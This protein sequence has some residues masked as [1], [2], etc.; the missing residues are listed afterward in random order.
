M[1][2]KILSI[3]AIALAL[4]VL[5]ITPA[6]ALSDTPYQGYIYDSYDKSNPAPVGYEPEKVVNQNVLGLSSIGRLYDMDFDKEGNLYVLDSDNS[7]IYIL[8]VNLQLKSTLTLNQDGEPVNFSKAQ[9]IYIHKTGDEKLI[10]IAD[11]EQGR[12]LVSDKDGNVVNVFT[13]PET[14]LIPEST[15][16]RP[17]KVVVSDEETVY[18]LCQHVYSGVLML[19]Q[20]GEFLGFCG[21]NKIEMT[22]AVLF[23]YMWK[24]L[25]SEDLKTSQS[26]YVPVEYS[27][28][29]IDEEGYLLACSVSGTD[30]TESIRRL[31][32]KGNNIFPLETVFGDLETSEIGEN[33]VSTT[34]TD[35]TSIGEGVFAA[36]DLALGRVFV[37]DTEG[38][39]LLS[40]GT[41]GN[42]VGTFKTPV[43]IASYSDYVYVLDQATNTITMFTVNDYGKT[44]LDASRSYLKGL[45]NES[46]DLWESVLVQ[47][48]AFE[49]AYVSI[50]RS[51]I[52]LEDYKGA[53]KYFKLGQSRVD[54]SRAFQEYRTRLIS[55]WFDVIF[56]AII[57][58]A[59]G[60]FIFFKFRKKKKIGYDYEVPDG[61]FRRL[62]LSLAHP[63]RD[64]MAFVN[65]TKG[66]FWIAPFVAA[67]WFFEKVFTYQMRGFI[68]NVNDPAKMDIRLLFIGSVGLFVLFILSNWLIC[69]MFSLSG[70][71]S[72]IATVTS[73]AILPYIVSSILNT[74]LSNFLT[75]EEGMFMT[76]I[77]V[78]AIAWGV[79]ILFIGLSKIHEANIV[80]TL[81][82][83]LATLLG[84]FVIVFLVLVFF[85]LW[86]QFIDFCTA[87][88]REII[89]ILR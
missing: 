60:L 52:N 86:Q 82:L 81:V 57:V 29:D 33:V 55:E 53:M 36:L 87:V 22:A 2:K 14:S 16:F 72:Q 6:A 4:T 79:M 12:I 11:T 47:N 38:S 24:K 50:G 65:N 8:D 39:F 89:G 66:S 62:M 18:I 26:R 51:L 77:T 3:A 85:S 17:T 45:Y 40:F 68:F 74:I 32:A 64:M 19:N 42:Q 69:T 10:Y 35:V 20:Y 15:E 56:I 63:V 46:I 37:Y 61:Y 27:G 75:D 31:N 1:K 43:A 48:G 21:S 23:N 73:L 5:L 70:K 7:S 34:F 25:L 84:I 54:Y 80:L 78:L 28:L 76:I 88:I 67:L 30:K 44:V 59:V 41:L 9:G 71:L 13:R 49:T 83:V 58:I